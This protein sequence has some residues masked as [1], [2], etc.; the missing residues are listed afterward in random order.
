VYLVLED[1]YRRCRVPVDA[2][3][4]GGMQGHE[5][6]VAAV[7]VDDVP[8]PFDAPGVARHGDDVLEGHVVG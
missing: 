4:V 7:Q 6:A 8:P 2:K 1:G 5:V 3:V